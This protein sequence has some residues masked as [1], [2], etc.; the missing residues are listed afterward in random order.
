M[1]ICAREGLVNNSLRYLSGA[2]GTPYG[3]RHYVLVQM[4]RKLQTISFFLK[5]FHQV[6]SYCQLVLE[7]D[8]GWQYVTPHCTWCSVRAVCS[9]MGFLVVSLELLTEWIWVLPTVGRDQWLKLA[10]E[11]KDPQDSATLKWHSFGGSWQGATVNFTSLCVMSNPSIM[12]L[13][14]SWHTLW[15]LMAQLWFHSVVLGLL[16]VFWLCRDT[17]LLPACGTWDCHAKSPFC[18]YSCSQVH[19]GCRE[20]IWAAERCYWQ[21]RET[22][23]CLWWVICWEGADKICRE[24]DLAEVKK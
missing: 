22:L 20:W 8:C 4:K 13:P 19:L 3:I 11:C 2:W 1:C 10:K 15:L 9:Y 7:G 5:D 14:G 16:H 18:P 21:W 6:F 12:E 24:P 17:S 23:Q